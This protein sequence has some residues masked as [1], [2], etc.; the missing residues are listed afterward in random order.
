[1]YKH[2][3]EIDQDNY[4]TEA[5]CNAFR[6][7]TANSIC[8]NEAGGRHFHLQLMDVDG[9][10]CKKW[11]GLAIIDSVPPLSSVIGKKL[12]ELEDYHYTADEVRRITINS[13]IKFTTNSQD[14]ALI[15]EQIINIQQQI[16]LGTYPVSPKFTYYYSNT[17]IDLTLDQLKS[18]YIFCMNT[19]NQNY[20]VY[21]NHREAIKK[22]TTIT[23]VNNYNFTAKYLKN[24]NFDLT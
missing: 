5:F 24:N 7:P 9:H 13:E 11:D 14:R 16:D 3:I 21:Q 19:V 17:S 15:V 12:G 2:Y 10:L 22:L 8:V 23:K 1:M 20:Q 6:Q 4:I 18:V